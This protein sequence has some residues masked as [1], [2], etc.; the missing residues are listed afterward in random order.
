VATLGW[1]VLT[2]PFWT[3]LVGGPSVTHEHQVQGRPTSSQEH[4]GHL[5]VHDAAGAAWW[6]E[7]GG[8]LLLWS[9]MALAT[10][11]PLI[12]WN[13]RRVGLRSPSTRGT[14]ATIE[15]AVGWAAIWLVTGVILS[16][17]LMAATRAA[18]TAFVVVATVA[19]A[20]AWQFAGVRRV[21]VARCH[22]TFAPPLGRAAQ[23]ACVR[24]GGALGRDC[25]VSCWA[26]MA[27]MAAAGHRL[28]VVVPVA[29]LSW[30]DRRRPHDRPGTGVSV[31]VLVLAGFAVL[32]LLGL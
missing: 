10:M 6:S 2:A 27:L 7:L 29:W 20:I 12:A 15:V 5:A 18:G 19:V 4:S 3:P 13:L 30:R 8:H 28:A 22:R 14:R 32:V 24:F 23:R 9:A 16:V 1:V 26:S 17:A 11:L 25:V 31:A 21:A